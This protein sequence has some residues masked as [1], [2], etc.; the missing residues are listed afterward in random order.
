MKEGFAFW[1]VWGIC[2]VIVCLLL[3]FRPDAWAT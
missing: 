2:V 1:T 3:I